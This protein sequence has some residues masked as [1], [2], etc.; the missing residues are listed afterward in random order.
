MVIYLILVGCSTAAEVELTLSII[1]PY[2]TLKE[3]VY[4]QAKSWRSYGTHWMRNS[5]RYPTLLLHNARNIEN[6]IFKLYD[7]MGYS[8]A[9]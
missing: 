8:A 4:D 5:K 1:V 3:W 2:I 9:L 6:W 7:H